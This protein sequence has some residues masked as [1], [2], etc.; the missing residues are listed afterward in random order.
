MIGSKNFLENFA[1]LLSGW[2]PV[3]EIPGSNFHNGTAENQGKG[4]ETESKK[5]GLCC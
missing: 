2:F 3:L 1:Y 5:L 4:C